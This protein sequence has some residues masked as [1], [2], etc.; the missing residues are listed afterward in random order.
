MAAL[1]GILHIPRTAIREVRLSKNTAPS[2]IDSTP[3]VNPNSNSVVGNHERFL[4]SSI[5]SPYRGDGEIVKRTSVLSATTAKLSTNPWDIRVA[6]FH[7]LRTSYSPSSSSSSSSSSTSHDRHLPH[8][9][10]LARF[11]NS[12]FPGRNDGLLLGRCRNV[13][14]QPPEKPKSFME[15]VF[16]NMKEEFKKNKEMKENLRKFRE[17][18][19][20]L[21]ESEALKEARGKFSQVLDKS[22]SSNVIKEKLDEIKESEFVKKTSKSAEEIGS[23]TS[24]TV[25]ETVKN[26]SETTAFKKV[27]EGVKVAKDTVQEELNESDLYNRGRVYTRPNALQ[28]RSDRLVRMDQAEKTFDANED[29]TEMVMHKDSKFAQSWAQ[30]KENNQYVNKMFEYKMKYD[31]SDHLAVRMSRAVTEKV[32]TVFGSMFSKTEMSEVLTEICKMDPGFDPVSFM[33]QCREDIIPNIVEAMVQGNLE[34]LED[35][36]HEACFNQLAVPIK[37]AEQQKLLFDNRVLDFTEPELV[38]AKIMEQG[39]VLVIT[40]NSQQIMVLR[41]KKGDI[42]EGDPEKILR[43]TYVMALCRDQEILD[44]SAC[45]RLLDLSASSATQWL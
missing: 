26:I 40:F 23:K 34:V 13:S 39:P 7:S 1:R 20:K 19:K 38:A 41:D 10:G 33:K 28:K 30:F 25:S 5:V 45:W 18:A 3:A 43:V 6:S 17:E 16:S 14:T 2:V 11:D 37:A 31:E 22:E 12:S 4:S 32:Q 9:S 35:W 21:E 24:E 36:C 44:P 29:A 42:I 27:S 8:F 15:G